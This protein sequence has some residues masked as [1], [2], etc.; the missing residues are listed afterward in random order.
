M[1]SADMFALHGKNHVRDSLQQLL[2]KQ[3]S[4]LDLLPHTD[5]REKFIDLVLN[6]EPLNLDH[7][8]TALFHEL[9]QKLTEK[10]VEDVR[11]VVFGGGTGLSNIIGGDS[12]SKGWDQAPFSGLKEIFPRTRSVVCVTDDGGS[13]GELLKDLPLVAIGDIRHVLLSSVQL[14]RLQ[15]RYSLSVIEAKAVVAV[16]STLFNYRFN[17]KPQGF[18]QVLEDCGADLRTLPLSLREYLD[19]ILR[20]IFMDSR[21]APT[22]ERPHC[23]GN[24]LIVATVFR[25][26]D[27]ALTI[28]VLEDSPDVLHQALFNGLTILADMLGAEKRAVLPCTSTP[29]QLRVLYTNG[30]QV[31]GETKSSTALRGVPVKRVYVD[32]SGPARVYPEILEDI[33]KADIL[34]MA[35]GSLYSSIIPIFHVPGMADAVRGNNHALKLL[36]SNLWVQSGETDRSIAD[37]DRKFHVSDMLTAYEENIPGGTEGLFHEVLCLS[38]KDVPASILQQYEIEGK[39][40]IYLDRHRVCEQ[41]FIPIECGIYSKTALAERGVIQHDP[42]ILAQAIKTIFVGSVCYQGKQIR[43]LKKNQDAGRRP[44]AH[45][46]HISMLPSLK[47]KQIRNHIWTLSIAHDGR[48]S[49]DTEKIRAA[50]CD[51][52]WRHQ[53]IPLSHLHYV[54][55]INCISDNQWRRDQKWDNVFSYFDPADCSLR[56]RHDQI[57]DERRLETAFLI[58]LGESLLGNYA[59]KKEMKGIETDGIPV[60]KVYHLLLRPEVQRRCFLQAADLHNYLV[61][62]RMLPVKGNA[63][64]YTRLINGDEGFTPPGL[65]MGLTYAWY[66]ENRL[67]NHIEYKM[68]LTRINQCDLIPEQMK[69]LQRRERVISFFRD[70]VFCNA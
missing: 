50:I 1:I 54:T 60:G 55:A 35:P 42:E 36:I 28:E 65:L 25:E 40:P 15:K 69:M 46:G 51:I 27:R 57:A 41:G 61:L 31:T 24:M 44:V 34:I 67:A 32:F 48:K 20:Y 21:L 29:A 13:T 3:L 5:L 63:F 2:A 18:E 62:A 70:V 64:H 33:E 68:S 11:I 16:L 6:G 59:E 38:L 56:I 45:D 12:R 4:P 26:I 43:P 9:R 19:S 39:I 49:P 10:R 17:K 52:I 58:A 7:E 53:D 22:L 14:A 23:L 8:T 30:V 37:P 66:L 47:F